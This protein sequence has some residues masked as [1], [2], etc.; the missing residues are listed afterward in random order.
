MTKKELEKEAKERAKDY[1]ENKERQV[2][3]GC[4]FLDGADVLKREIK[5]MQERYNKQKEINKELV[6]EI[7]ELRN[8]GFTV[9]AMTEQKLKL[10]LEKGEQLEKENAELKK[11]K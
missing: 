5:T 4:G 10:A 9:S 8:N 1:T 3:Y 11:L 6:E 7:E 2:A